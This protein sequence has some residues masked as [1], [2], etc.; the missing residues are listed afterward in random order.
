MRV[1]SNNRGSVLGERRRE[2]PLGRFSAF[3]S[4]REWYVGPNRFRNWGRRVFSRLCWAY[5]D[6]FGHMHHG[7]SISPQPTCEIIGIKY[8]IIGSFTI[9]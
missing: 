6:S 4:L 8:I 1:G 7:Q 9:G 3:L 5:R 2:T